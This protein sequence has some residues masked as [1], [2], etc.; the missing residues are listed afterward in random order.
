M[1]IVHESA[2]STSVA[3]HYGAGTIAAPA[4]VPTCDTC[5]TDEHLIYEE[6]VPARLAIRGSDAEPANAA[7]SCSECG[8]FSAHVVPAS[9]CP[10]NW[11]FYR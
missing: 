7:Y 10:P 8:R 9:W 3:V 2:R 5:G 6:Y 11:S 1:S 4:Q